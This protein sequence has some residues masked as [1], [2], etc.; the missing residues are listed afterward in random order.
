[1]SGLSIKDLEPFSFLI[2]GASTWGDGDLQEDWD[3]FLPVL[4]KSDLSD[5]TIALFG[6][7]D[8][9]AYSDTFVDAIGILYDELKN[10]GAAFTGFCE[11]EGYSFD[12]SRALIDGKFAGLPLDDENENEKTPERISSWV[13]SIVKFAE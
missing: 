12:D 9:S 10:T 6:T 5:K 7:G 4:G 11:T 2:L 3:S 1:M 8:A 13:K